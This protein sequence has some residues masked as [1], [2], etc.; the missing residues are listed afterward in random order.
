MKISTKGRYALRLMVDLAEH[1]DAN[2]VSLQ[3]IS[4]RHGISLKYL[5]S[6]V[7]GLVKNG[8]LD[9][10]HG[11]GGGYKLNKPAEEYKVGEI[12]RIAEG[13]L[14]PVSCEACSGEHCS[15][16]GECK[17]KSMWDKLGELINDYLDGISL[18]DL[19]AM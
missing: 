12:L 11:K 7:A 19:L 17:T 3:E 5:E 13:D 15:Q 9:S 1:P 16:M 10:I 2:C 8:L 18:A 6:I 4:E 14:A